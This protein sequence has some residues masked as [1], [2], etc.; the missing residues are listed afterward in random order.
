MRALGAKVITRIY[1]GS[2]HGI[3]EDEVGIPRQILSRIAE[4]KLT[5]GRSA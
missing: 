2:N 1:P 3:N 5:P 4:A